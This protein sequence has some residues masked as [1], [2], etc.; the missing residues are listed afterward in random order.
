M[1]AIDNKYNIGDDVA[2][3]RS[4]QQFAI[5]LKEDIPTHQVERIVIREGGVLSYAV[6]YGSF[7]EDELV[8]ADDVKSAVINLLK[9]RLYQLGRQWGIAD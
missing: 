8:R 4:I 2:T 6:N 9:G 5:G 3:M 7:L 1:L